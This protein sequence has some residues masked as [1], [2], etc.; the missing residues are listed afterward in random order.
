MDLSHN[1]LSGEIPQQLTGLTLLQSFDLSHNNLTGPI[2]QGNQFGTFENTS[3]EGNPGLCGIPLPKKC[4]DSM[5]LPLP[6]SAVEEEDDSGSLIELDW[7]FI[8][9]G[10]TSGFV[11]GVALGDMLASVAERANCKSILKE[12]SAGDDARRLT[13][14]ENTKA[15]IGI[16]EERERL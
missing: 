6:P 14:I 4:E 7:K 1:N 12:T 3:F 8:L 16:W 9:A 5:A 13:L 10:G 15:W 11:V 2:P